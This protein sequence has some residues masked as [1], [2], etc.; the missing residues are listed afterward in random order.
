MP[1][2]AISGLNLDLVV[3]SRLI[4]NLAGPRTD[5]II[6]CWQ[7]HN[8][9]SRPYLEEQMNSFIVRIMSR[10]KLRQFSVEN[11]M[12]SIFYRKQKTVNALYPTD[13]TDP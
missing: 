1:R 9:N 2:H 7:N 13:C 12:T 3:G 4:Y 11:K 5:G 8:Q 10:P 6:A